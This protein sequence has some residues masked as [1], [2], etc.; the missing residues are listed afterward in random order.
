M[1]HAPLVAAT[2]VLCNGLCDCYAAED[3]PRPELSRCA[4]L[5]R[6][7]KHDVPSM[8]AHGIN[9]NHAPLFKAKIVRSFAHH[10]APQRAPLDRETLESSRVDP[11]AVP[12]R[13]AAS[14]DLGV[15]D[16][17]GDIGA[18][19]APEVMSSML[20]FKEISVDLAPVDL[21]AHEAF[22]T[23]LFSFVMQLP[24][25]DIWQV[26]RLHLSAPLLCQPAAQCHM[27]SSHLP[28]MSAHG[29]QDADWQK[30]NNAAMMSTE[31]SHDTRLAQKSVAAAQRELHDLRT[32]EHPTRQDDSVLGSWFF[33][34]KFRISDIH[35]NVTV[36]ISSHIMATARLFAAQVCTWPCRPA[37]WL[38]QPCPAVWASTMVVSAVPALCR[39]R[40]HVPLTH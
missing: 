35:S 20:S 18:N 11:A 25:D 26:R 32:Y 30:K 31:V 22:L 27:P 39:A 19:R 10:T 4:G 7:V 34:E 40:A 29:V 38:T 17:Q 36:S 24:L 3:A 2:A 5:Q 13:A 28:D 15:V 37:Q 9:E 1:R 16:A 21:T 6:L 14:A 8:T 23:S 12:D 33:I